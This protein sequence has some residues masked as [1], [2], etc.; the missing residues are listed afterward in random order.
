M[1]R[2]SDR[3]GRRAVLI[4]SAAIAAAF[5]FGIGWFVAGSPLLL[6]ALVIAYSF[7]AIGDSPVLST[8]LAERVDPASLGAMLAVR[9]L[10]GFIV[11]AISPAVVG[12]VIDNM[13]VAGAGDT[14]VWGSAFCTLGLGGVLAV[15]FASRL[16]KGR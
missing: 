11:A 10:S 5:S 3:A 6:A 7:F 2:L 16:P 8:A 13:R 4:G 14:L 15:W 12:L 1:G 9:S